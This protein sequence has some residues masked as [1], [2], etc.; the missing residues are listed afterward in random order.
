MK[1][2]L[3]IAQFS[4]SHLFADINGLHCEVNVYQNL[5]KVLTSIANNNAIDFVVF[6]GDLTQDHSENAYQNFGRA[7][8]ESKLTTPL[9]YTAGN[10]DDIAL[11]EYFLAKSPCQMQKEVSL[12]SWH[13][14]LINSKSSTPAGF[15]SQNTLQQLGVQHEHYPYQI[16][17]MHHHPLDVGYFIDEHG[18]ENKQAFWQAIAHNTHIKAIACGH[19]HRGLSITKKL[20]SHQVEVFTCP[21]SSIQFDPNAKGVKALTG[22]AGQAAYRCFYLSAQGEISSKIYKV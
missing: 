7:I 17:F 14:K 21:A 3:V 18:L 6:T 9:Y 11:L 19:V 5:V 12:K 16:I 20:L 8:Q 10:H 2:N 1:A 15:I 22:I 4:D 13:I